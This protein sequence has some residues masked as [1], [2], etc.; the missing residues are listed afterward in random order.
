MKA[1]VALVLGVPFG[2]ML[3][4]SGMADPDVIRGALLLEDWY[5]YKMFAAAVAV[6]ALG[7]FALRRLSARSL[8]DGEPIRLDS[9]PPERRHVSGS[10]VFG[11]GWAVTAACPGPVAA[12][13]ASGLWWS[14]FTIL[15][16]ALGILLF[17]ARQDASRRDGIATPAAA[18]AASSP[19]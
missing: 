8:L 19:R 1:L 7:S 12:Q 9:G 10:V 15:G 5:L 3:A 2:F 18:A 16:I 6:G 13:A 11:L 4:W 17:F 14:A